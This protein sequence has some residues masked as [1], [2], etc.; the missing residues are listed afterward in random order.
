MTTWGTTQAFGMTTLTI[1]SFC[2]CSCYSAPDDDVC[3]MLMLV[4][5][6]GFC[7]TYD[8]DVEHL[9]ENDVEPLNIDT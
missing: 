4:M 7:D 1:V 8:D 3:T 2:S 9:N 6:A 5:S